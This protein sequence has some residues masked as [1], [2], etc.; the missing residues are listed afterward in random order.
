MFSFLIDFFALQSVGYLDSRV[1]LCPG[2]S[3]ICHSSHISPSQ[4]SRKTTHRTEGDNIL[5]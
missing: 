3:Y 1:Y 4:I 2:D 5:L